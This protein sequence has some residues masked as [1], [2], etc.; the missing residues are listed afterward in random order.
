MCYFPEETYQ[1]PRKVNWVDVKS[2]SEAYPILSAPVDF[3]HNL[4]DEN[5]EPVDERDWI[6]VYP[7][8]SL[9]ERIKGWLN[10]ISGLG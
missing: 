9:W 10:T 2:L 6:Q 1:V 5:G 3:F 4:Y 8:P 7:L